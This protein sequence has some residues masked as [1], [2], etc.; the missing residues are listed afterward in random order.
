MVVTHVAAT[1]LS[2]LTSFNPPTTPKALCGFGFV[3]PDH[4]GGATAVYRHCAES[5]VLVR[6]DTDGRGH[7]TRCVGPW[8]TV[9]FWADEKV[10]NAYYVPV[11]PALLDLGDR[12]ICS[13]SQPDA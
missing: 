2:V 1:I 10:V 7:Y 8:A 5:F 6:V 11:A 13:L 3:N 4:H 9:P 12:R